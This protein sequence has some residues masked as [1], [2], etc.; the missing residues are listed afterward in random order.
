MQT[1]VDVVVVG[2]GVSG[3]LAAASL[4]VAGRSVVVVDK[5][6]SV[7]G[8]LATRRLGPADLPA[9]QQ[10]RAD[11]GAQ[12]FTVRT[13]RFARLVDPL[14]ADGL[15]HAWTHGFDAEPDGHPR[16]AVRG[17]MTAL[18]KHL[19]DVAEANGAEIRTGCR[20]ERVTTDGRVTAAPT[21]SSHPTN[22][23]RIAAHGPSWQAHR[24]VLTS[25]VPQTIELLGGDAPDALGAIS[26][27]PTLC[28]LG[29]LE[30][31][32]GTGETPSIGHAGGIQ[33]PD[34]LPFEFVADNAA[35]GTSPTPTL[36]AHLTADESTA[37]WDDPD[38]ATLAFALDAVGPLLGGATVVDPQLKRWRYATPTTL[39]PEPAL[40]EG[41]L[42]FGGDA[43]GSPRIEGAATSGWAVA[44]SLL[45]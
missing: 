14:V 32:P 11:H 10:A 18:A 36:T 3:L 37:R 6:R 7:G 23:R 9:A 41:R 17:G 15:V 2:A 33:R 45:R 19:A 31:G 40:V 8:R 38:D 13:D 5:G 1:R 21:N 27:S 39:H 4:A 28:L 26:Y 44:D 12:F 43:F 25:P 20:V 24:V 30:P 16:Y 29:R 42:A 34:G 35:R 22:R